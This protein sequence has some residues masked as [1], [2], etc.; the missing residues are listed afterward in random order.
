MKKNILIS[1]SGGLDSTTLLAY[2]LDKGFDVS[3]VSFTYGSKHNKY[4]NKAANDLLLF[5]RELYQKPIPS[6]FIDLSKIFQS[7]KSNLLLSGGA[8]PEGN[9]KDTTMQ[10]TVV[11]GR[12]LIFSSILSGIAE[13]NKIT[14][15][16]LGV[17]AGDH[18]IYPDC[19]PAFIQSLNETIKYSTDNKVQVHCPF[20]HKTK[21]EILR[22]GLEL[23][24][25]YHLTRTCYKNQ[26]TPCGKCGSC[27]ERLSSFAELGI[28][29]PIIYEK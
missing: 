19:R 27:D 12:N 2:Y 29:D 23:K 14:S 21:T 6:F 26:P 5:Y 25:P 1:F 20:L 17:H 22:I 3:V 28:K 16:G 7:I 24:V 8:I 4:E 18:F 10:Q 9:Y 13:S 11:P 15:I